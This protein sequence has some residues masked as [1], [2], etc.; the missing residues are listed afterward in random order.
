MRREHE[1]LRAYGPLA[2]VAVLACAVFVGSLVLGAHHIDGAEQAR[3][4][5]LIARDVPRRIVDVG[6]NVNPFVMWDEALT[7]LD[8]R[9]DAAWAH[10]NIASLT[11]SDAIPRV[12]VID[13]YGQVTYGAQRTGEISPDALA[14][15]A[16]AAAPAVAEVRR[17][18]VARVLP[19]N[20]VPIRASRVSLVDGRPAVLIAS[21]VRS[22]TG[23]V[24]PQAG[25]APVLV[26][27]SSVD[28][29]LRKAF[30]DR[31]LLPD[32]R[33]QVVAGAPS[34]GV[35]EVVLSQVGDARRLVMRWSPERPGRELLLRS[36]PFLALAGLGVFTAAGAVALHARSVTRKLVR[37]QAEARRLALQD[38]LTGLANRLLFSDRLAK[39][40]ARARRDR[41]GAAALMLI[42][43][44]RFKEVN[45][46]W[47]HEAGDELIQ[48]VARRLTALCR[49][50]DTV[51]R[52]GG[53]EF[54][55]IAW[56]DGASGAAS[57]ATRVLDA[58]SGEVQLAQ[59]QAPLA[60]SMGV[61]LLTGD[62]ADQAEA[63]RQADLALYR[64]K[65]RGRG[66]F[67]FFEQ[68]MD[69][70]LKS[71][72]A[73][74]AD[75][76]SAVQEEGLRFVYQPL[77]DASGRVTAVE[78]L[79]RWS[80]PDRGE[81]SPAQFIPLAEECGLISQIGA[82]VFR[83]A[84][85]DQRR[86]P[87]VRTAVNVSPLQLRRPGLIASVEAVLAATG[88]DP[89]T[90]DLEL[91]EGCLLQD[92]AKTHEVLG[93]LRG[94]GFRLV[95]D[96]FGTG[97]SS[98]SYLHR[99]PVQKIKLDRAFVAPLGE[100]AQADA[101]VAALIRMADALDLKVVAEGV[102]T[103]AQFERLSELGCNEFQ[104]WYFARPAP[105]EE[106]AALVQRANGPDA[107]QR[108]R[109]TV[110]P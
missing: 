67:T 52:L 79:T 2:A 9:V 46:T 22:D 55:V 53:D 40:Q 62:V 89:A 68:E 14:G 110:A 92:D 105:P 44:D 108:L 21:L 49:S 41:S 28:V 81:V 63:L 82:Q 17:A 99:Y 42:D 78:A 66:R 50:E 1:G 100:T 87:G 48:E 20:N 103:R 59:A 6:N 27:E 80:H 76:R 74:E 8:G 10:D 84:C 107:R 7:K 47:G 37:S 16:A 45:D 73:M 18:E 102:E 12:A 11:R 91:T 98:V 5:A 94:L 34:P 19:P 15:L 77:M 104:G 88:A 23:K 39:A 97:Y 31:F 13:R 93:A 64:S 58:L 36:A 65:E 106:V 38:P 101:I 72:K 25:R 85:D 24:K 95:L 96:D 75:L 56:A 86:W 35:A 26:V 71:R 54:A 43:L 60:C 83:S 4:Q 57:L 32:L 109:Q 61:T 33:V 90:M 69:A 30:A 51:A 29:S 70:A 3:E